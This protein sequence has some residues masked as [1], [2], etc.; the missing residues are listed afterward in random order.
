[1]TDHALRSQRLRFSHVAA[2][3]LAFI[4]FFMAARVSRT[5]FE[6]LPHLEDEVTYLFQARVFSRGN[7]VIETPQP[8]QAFWQPF[9]IDDP[10]TGNRFG[11][12]TPGWPALLAIGIKLG[13]GWV[14]NAF[15]GMLT[16]VVV[17]RL[18]RE[19]F[20][21]DVG[22]VAAA[23][24]AFS[25]MALLQNATLMG[26]PAAL[27]FFSL[28]MFAYWRME[29]AT[30]AGKRRLAL[31]FG[32]LAGVALGWLV[33]IRPLS[34][35][36]V[37]IPF[38]LWSMLRAFSAWWDWRN[39]ETNQFADNHPLFNTVRP[40]FAIVIVTSI[41]GLAIPLYNQVATGEAFTNLYTE[42]WSYDQVGFG[43]CCGR[44]QQCRD[45]CGDDCSDCGHTIVKGIRQTRW[46]LSLMA[47]DL[48][49]WQVEY[50][51]RDVGMFTL[52]LFKPGRITPELQ[53]HLRTESDYWPLIGLSFFILPLGLFM[54]FRQ[55]RLRV[56]LLIGLLWLIIPL[57]EDMDFLRGVPWVDNV[58]N[59]TPVWRWLAVGVLWMLIPPFI[60]LRIRR[61]KDATPSIWT[62]LLLSVVVGLVGIH[63]AY[64]IGSQRYSTRYYYEALSA[65]AIIGAL[66]IAWLARRINRVAVYS[67]LVAVIL[68]SLVSYSIPRIE[69]L[70][71]FNHINAAMIEAVESR[72]ISDDIPVLVVVTNSPENRARWRSFGALM[73]ITNPYLDSDIVVAWDYPQG[74][75]VR[76]Q[77]L[78]RFPDRQVIDM[79]AAG[80]EAW[81][82]DPDCAQGVSNG[83][84]DCI[85]DDSEAP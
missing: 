75:S 24:A 61:R 15:C 74:A 32:I 49:G 66:P 51:P 57:V 40:L 55:R 6:R 52:P 39:G 37:T 62:W 36:G 80:N 58:P 34:A 18:G 70:K 8:Q 63:L 71:G 11:K 1:M 41:I 5:V 54:G 79:Q 33:I 50:T 56:W 29:K 19:I 82:V 35:I 44:D 27:L 3:I 84:E 45:T 43:E 25:P 30:G 67:I 2:L 85:T 28:F 17:Y 65:L 53:E 59:F 60:L 20:N 14:I 69:A 16:V 42:V 64:W 12:Y 77:I 13:Q 4:A 68:W 31:R 21:P 81:F 78:S 73:A 46:D 26:H 10:D 76:T 7:I 9:V 48:F 47:A 72:R 38:I 22:L 23:L 83:A